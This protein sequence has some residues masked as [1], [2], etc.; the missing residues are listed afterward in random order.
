MRVEGLR[1]PE[2]SEAAVEEW[3][4]LLDKLPECLLFVSGTAVVSKKRGWVKSSLVSLYAFRWIPGKWLGVAPN[5]E[6]I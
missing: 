6:I 2:V 5:S 4:S 3:E 1:D